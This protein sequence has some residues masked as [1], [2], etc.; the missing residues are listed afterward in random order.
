MNIS[1]VLSLLTDQIYYFFTI[2]LKNRLVST[3]IA[4]KGEDYYY[5]LF[6]RYRTT[7]TD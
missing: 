3:L 4:C 5:Y 7:S 1:I 2:Q 6:I